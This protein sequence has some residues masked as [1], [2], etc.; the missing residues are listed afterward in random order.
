MCGV[1]YKKS[2]ATGAAQLAS[3]RPACRRRA[4]PRAA[5]VAVPDAGAD[6]EPAVEQRSLPQLLRLRRVRRLRLHGRS[7]EAED[8]G[9]GQ[10]ISKGEARSHFKK[11]WRHK[12][13][14]NST[15]FKK[16]VHANDPSQYNFVSPEN[17]CILNLC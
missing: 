5:A 1:S 7:R 3:A 4:V 11:N 10:R 17:V 15:F 9:G 2:T 8:D 6:R 14:L 12:R 13:L 16:T